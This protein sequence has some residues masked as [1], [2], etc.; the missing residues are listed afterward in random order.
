VSLATAYSRL[1]RSI[2]G[3]LSRNEPLARHTSYRIGGPADLWVVCDTTADVAEALTILTEEHIPYTVIGKGT[4]LLVADEGYRGA[5]V[6]LGKD[7]KKHVR[8]GARIEAGAA[9]ILAYVVQDAF[10]RGL[11]GLEFAVGIPGTV[12][13]ALAMNAGSRDQWIGSVVESVTLYVPGTGMAA[14][15]GGATVAQG[16]GTVE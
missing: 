15:S 3:T 10:S 13:G 16:S 4:N 7:F 12:G 8:D 6:I 9:C 1:S 5:V 2:T 14:R 11:G